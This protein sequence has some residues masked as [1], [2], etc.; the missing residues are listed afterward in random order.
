MGLICSVEKIKITYESQLANNFG[1]KF[2]ETSCKNNENVSPAFET[3]AAMIKLKVD[4]KVCRC[5]FWTSAA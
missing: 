3:L 5:N 2:Y 1:I 4:E